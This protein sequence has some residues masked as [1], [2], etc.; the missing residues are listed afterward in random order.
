M[1]HVGLWKAF[2]TG[3]FA[4][5]H[6]ERDHIAAIAR[7]RGGRI[8][9]EELRGNEVVV[10]G[11]TPLDIKCA[12]AIGAKAL[13]VATGGYSLAELAEHGPDWVVEDL[14]KIRAA[15]VVT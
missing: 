12:R 14:G 1:R 4:D 10:V 5:D 6:E 2:E 8:L 11:D 15:K 7:Q 9:N 3:A 13:A